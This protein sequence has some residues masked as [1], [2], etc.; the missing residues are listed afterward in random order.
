MFTELANADR[1]EIFWLGLMCP[2]ILALFFLTLMVRF[3]SAWVRA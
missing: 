1:G 3:V 2:P